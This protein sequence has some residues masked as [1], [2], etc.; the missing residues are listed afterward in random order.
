MMISFEEFKK[1]DIRIGKVLA[2][3]RVPGSD[4]LMR[5]EVDIGEEKRQLIAGVAQDYGPEDLLGKE[6]PVLVNLEPKTF[7][8][9]ESQGMI[10]AADADGRPVLLY[11]EK[12]VSPGSI[13]K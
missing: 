9:L 6:L 1:L 3:D 13:I 2:A 7:K 5:L 10:L 11:P 8:G 12:S 4:K